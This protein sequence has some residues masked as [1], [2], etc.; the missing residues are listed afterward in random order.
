MPNIT[1]QVDDVNYKCNQLKPVE[2]V[3][4][5]NTTIYVV[6]PTAYT[7]YIQSCYQI[8]PDTTNI[9]SGNKINITPVGIL[10]SLWLNSFG[11]PYQ[12]T[13]YAQAKEF[14]F[15]EDFNCLVPSGLES[16]SGVI[17]SVNKKFIEIDNGGRVQKLNLGA[18]SR[19]ESTNSLP[20]VGQKI[21]FRGQKLDRTEF[22]LYKGSCVWLSLFIIYLLIDENYTIIFSLKQF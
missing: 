17:K 22:N 4:Q 9:K 11:N 13:S 18:C 10:D 3:V 12:P 8:R 19:L 21:Y 14:T 2:P 5:N 7:S 20:K 6:Q 15:K 16:G 1:K